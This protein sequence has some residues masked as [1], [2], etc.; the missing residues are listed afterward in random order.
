MNAQ[1]TS[2]KH[3]DVTGKELLYL[4]IEV[5]NK[6]DV[7]INVGQKTFDK[8]NNLFTLTEEKQKGGKK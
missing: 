7:L 2:I 1:I 4:K 8:V 5:A 6:P 3:K